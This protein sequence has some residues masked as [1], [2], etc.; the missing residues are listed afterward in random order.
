MRT[1][2]CIDKFR[3]EDGTITSYISASSQF[4]AVGSES[5]VVN[6][7]KDNNFNTNTRFAKRNPIKSIMNIHTT[8]DHMKFNPDGQILAM[9]SRREKDV[10][11]LLHVPT[12]TVFSNWPTTKTPLSY[13]WSMDFSPGSKY[14][15]I[16]NDKGTCLLYK[17]PHY[18]DV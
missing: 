6:M 16:G 3:N 7:Y 5:G 10:L 9:S 12:Q 11:K 13:V 17:L 2:K 15:A 18:H 4:L 8:I 1:K 14:M